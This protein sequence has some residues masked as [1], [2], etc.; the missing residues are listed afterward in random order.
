M[1]SNANDRTVNIRRA[2]FGDVLSIGLIERDSF[3]DPWGSR[4]FTS[5]LESEPVT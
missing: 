5:A 4:E 3:A 1:R 2:S